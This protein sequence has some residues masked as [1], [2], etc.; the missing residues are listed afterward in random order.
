MLREILH[1]ADRY[2]ESGGGWYILALDGMLL[3]P[4]AFSVFFFPVGLLIGLC[5]AAALTIGT[6]LVIRRI[7]A[8]H[9]RG[10]IM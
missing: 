10:V 3:I 2:I 8:H 9:H 6:L 4:V 7:H 5:V 1:S